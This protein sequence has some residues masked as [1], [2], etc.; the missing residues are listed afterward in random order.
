MNNGKIDEREF[1]R[2]I[3]ELEE[4][5][6]RIK[7]SSHLLNPSIVPKNYQNTSSIKKLDK[8]IDI[9]RELI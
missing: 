4:F 2:R 1:K 9:S 3:N 8:I 5:L 7:S 6:R